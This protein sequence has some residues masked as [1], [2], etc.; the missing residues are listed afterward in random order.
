M[1]A[2]EGRAPKYCSNPSHYGPGD[3]KCQRCDEGKIYKICK[4]IRY[5]AGIGRAYTDGMDEIVTLTCGICKTDLPR[6]VALPNVPEYFLMRIAFMHPGPPDLDELK[7]LVRQMLRMMCQKTGGET[8]AHT[9][10]GDIPFEGNYERVRMGLLNNGI[11]LARSGMLDNIDLTGPMPPT[12][13]VD[14]TKMKDRDR[15]EA[16]IRE[17]FW[18]RE[19]DAGTLKRLVDELEEREDEYTKRLIILETAMIVLS[20]R[21]EQ[22]NGFG[23]GEVRE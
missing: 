1:E 5:N 12:V 3:L 14:K 13:I 23:F 6:F 8:E 7:E 19:V 18:G 16:T 2:Q 9:V 11:H 4:D 20:G 17:I 21:L 22:V 10:K 15:N